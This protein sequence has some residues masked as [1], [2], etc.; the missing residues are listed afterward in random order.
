[1]TRSKVTT[2]FANAVANSLE[3][4]GALEKKEAP[5][6]QQE[7]QQDNP[8]G[9]QGGMENPVPKK[10]D[11]MEPDKQAYFIALALREVKNII[12]VA[13]FNL[14]NAL[15]Q[16]KPTITNMFFQRDNSAVVDITVPFSYAGENPNKEDFANVDSAF[17]LELRKEYAEMVEYKINKPSISNPDVSVDLSLT[18]PKGLLDSIGAN[19]FD[20]R[21]KVVTKYVE[22][23]VKKE[24]A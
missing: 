22:S 3:D 7:G 17:D 10:I 20:T 8:K 6:D 2:I 24:L 4:A 12:D 16:E 14:K 13:N 18:L 21:T 15:K 9:Q 11:A 19:K 1:M 5:K 23:L